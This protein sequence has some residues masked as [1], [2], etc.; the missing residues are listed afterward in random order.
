MA[1]NESAE[2]SRL[3]QFVAFVALAVG[4][5]VLAGWS[6]D[7]IAL[8]NLVPGWPQ[9]SRITALGFMAAG[10]SLWLASFPRPRAAAAASL[11]LTAIGLLVLF[12]YAL[13]WDVYLDQFSLEPMPAIAPGGYPP[14]MA[15]ATAVAFCCFGMSIL[16]AL[17][18]TTAIAHQ[19][20]AIF[21]LVIGWMGLS[22]FIFGG[23]ALVP[24]V[25]VAAHGS[26]VFLLLGAG[27][28]TLRTD[29]GIARLLASEGVGG[30]IARRLLPAA[31]LV[32]LLAGAL[33]LHVERSGVL[34]HEAAV[35][36]FALSAMFVFTA[37]VLINAARGER[38]D[39][40]RRAAES[41]LRVSEERNQLVVETA[42]D[43]VVTIDHRGL[44]TGWNSHAEKLFGWLRAE[45]LGR[46]L[47]DLIIPARFREQHR[48]GMNRY[49]DSGVARVLNKRMEMTALHRDGTE[50][51]VEL[52]IT[53]IGFGEDLV[54]SAFIRD[55]TGRVLAESALRESEQ[56][57]R[58]TA[59]AAPVLIW[60]SG[61]D[62]RCTWFNQR[63]LDF[64]GRDIEQEL[65]DGWCDNLHPADFDRALDTYHAAFDARRAYEMEY[66]LQRDDGAWRWLLERGCPHLGPSGEFVGFIGTCIDITE[67]RETVEQLRENRARFK[68][69]A[70][71][72]PQMIWTC[73]RD[74]YTDYV[75]RQ[76]LDYTGRSEAQQLGSGWLEQVHPDDRVKVF[77]EWSRVVASGDTYDISYR[78]R[79]FD[80]V[81]R[82]FK[83]RAV[84][85][86]DPAGRILKWFGSNTDIEDFVVAE[87]KLK[88]QLERM[89]LLD[90]TTHAI[91]AHH[92]LRK[93]FEV[94]L[95]SIE[96][97]LGIDFVGLCTYQAEPEVI[98]VSCV[99]ERS[100]TLAKQIGLVE[101]A[102]IDVDDNGLK[103]C[104]HGELVYDADI[105]N[106]RFPFP[107]RLAKAGLR[108]LVAAPL[109]IESEV[110]GVL[111]V[112]KRRVDAFT[113][114]DCE[115]L[116][117]LASHVALAAHQARLYEALQGAYQDLRQTQQTVMQQERLRAL[118]QIASGIAHDINNALSPAAL[119]AQSMLAH[120]T[121]LSERS[122]EQLAVIQRA[123]DDVAQTV[124]RMR[125]FYL[126]RGMENTLAP[127]DLNQ[128]LMQVIDLTR[129]RW[130]NIP[131]EHG[132]VVKVES[133]LDAAMPEILGVESEVRDGLT[134][135]LL[136][137]VDA[138]PEGG[139]VTLR[140]RYLPRDNQVVVEVQDTGVGMSETTRSRC[141]EPFFTTK[142]ERGTGLGLP[143]VFG[144]VQRHG[145]DFEIDSELGRGTTMRMI[146]P[147]APTG[148]SVSAQ[149]LVTLPR[150][151]RLLLVDDDPLLLRSLRDSLELDDHEVVTA[152]GGQ[153]GID[154]FA[155]SVQSGEKFDAVITDLGMPYV[156]GRKVAARVRQLS[157]EVPIIMLTGWGHRLIAMSD[158]PEHVNRVL[159]KP[160]K[161]AELRGALSDLVAP[162]EVTR[163]AK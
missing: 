44:V 38:A 124:Q 108:S 57:F 160:P 30:S 4:V 103:R 78:I 153:A 121:G 102:R 60:M 37:F 6:L 35:S 24:F 34:G 147:C 69:L 14:R 139:T 134:N 7:M 67:H 162:K 93:V 65:G 154:A 51:P 10:A 2:S 54:F 156:D 129:A 137:A 74:G 5:F 94:V 101:Q 150:P 87:R 3:A 114:D 151:L 159:S 130:S 79:R 157:G 115:F 47:A 23:E 29:A 42:L 149:A 27:A 9:I 68:T 28:L 85:L 33:T 132:I 72:L 16:C 75:S 46:E 58:T 41:A 43:G 63:W 25:N 152:D 91:G 136:N 148:M 106:L 90:R 99:G 141:L 21:V 45:A 83:T 84:P 122:R 155:L 8:T 50:F 133:D 32:P 120:Q 109:M 123:I 56:R 97:N 53:P 20:L 18:K 117:Q 17:K 73:L 138:M 92:E 52:S 135:L 86:R 143:M 158:Q 31:V 82:W 128:I 76:W 13:S 59:N 126:P 131:Q 96:D 161:M 146:F 110:F 100:A 116:R 36:V 19:T 81:Y 127:I 77:S 163:E 11:L 12:R 55:I 125:T 48:N 26:I 80:G 40:S 88:V 66:R 62:K 105:E 70:E 142:G 71:S 98:T 89:Q 15:P 95:R 145:G 61:K 104:V 39:S 64:V 111:L 49:L 118:S 119:Y 107:E 144:M 22:R 1:I 112:A 113:S 140:T